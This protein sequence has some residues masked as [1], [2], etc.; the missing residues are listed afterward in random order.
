MFSV[1]N[2]LHGTTCRPR[3]NW[4]AKTA[5]QPKFFVKSANRFCPKSRCRGENFGTYLLFAGCTFR[6][7]GKKFTRCSGAAVRQIL[8]AFFVTKDVLMATEF[9]LYRE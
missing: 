1:K 3:C 8:L 4:L 9:M 6:A 7:V 5:D 2:K